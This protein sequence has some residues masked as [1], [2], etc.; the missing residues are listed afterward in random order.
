MSRLRR[1]RLPVRRA[2][3][4][5]AFSSKEPALRFSDLERRRMA[6]MAEVVE[7]IVDAL[8][9]RQEHAQRVGPDR[10]VA[11][12]GPLDGFAIGQRMSDG[13]DRGDALGRDYRPLG[14]RALEAE[15][16]CL[17]A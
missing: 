2:F 12:G 17:G 14:V 10:D 9:F 16:P 6:Q 5:F 7:V 11:V 4:C 8:H 1:K 3:S 13:S 15:T